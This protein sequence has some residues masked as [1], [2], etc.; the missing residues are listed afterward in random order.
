MQLWTIASSSPRHIA[1]VA[2]AAEDAGLSGVVVTDSQNLA[3]DCYVALAT[4]AAVTT[5][6]G[7]GTGVTN[8]VTRHPA[9]TAAAIAAI[10]EVSGGRASLG[11]G[12][13]DSALAHLGR[14]PA[15]VDA[16]TRY[17]VVLQQYLRGE[18]VSF[19]ALDFHEQLAPPIEDLRLADTPTSSRLVW[20]A[21]LAKVPVEVAAT[22]PK[23]IAAA[24]LHADRVLL[25][26]GADPERLAWGINLGRRARTDAGL[27]PDGVRFGCYANVVTHPDV[28]TA[29]ALVAGGLATFARFSVMHG[30]ATGPQSEA[31]RTTLEELH[32]RYDMVHHTRS[33]SDQASVLPDEF[34]D[35]YAVVGPVEQC[36]EKLRA[37]EALGIDK[38]IAIGPT[39]GSDPTEARRANQLFT[40]EVVSAVV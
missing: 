15:S 6:I 30:T 40:A 37:I 26:V 27:D 19:D 38:V 10:Q 36:V 34:V 25:A 3:G 39:A 4:A 1:R 31:S 2:R 8:P 14:G 12:R 29:R 17:L 35:R 28:A 11:I 7:L 9:V 32:R 21:K 20:I 23:V 16:L 5:K 22:G 33:D 24:A 18:N 13:G